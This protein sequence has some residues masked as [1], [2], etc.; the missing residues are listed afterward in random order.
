LTN[1]S[2]Y[3]SM[4][5]ADLGLPSKFQSFRMAQK[6]A[7]EWLME[8]CPSPTSAACL[9]TGVGKTA[10]AIAL[11]RL[12]GVKT[13]YLVATKQLQEQV[14]DEFQSMGMVDIRGR[15]NYDCPN[16]GNCEIGSDRECS[17]FN[18][19]GCASSN[20]DERAE[21]AD[22]IVS[23]YACWLHRR[24][25]NR[26]AFEWE[27]RPIELVILDEAHAIES[28]L[29][30]YASFRFTASEI[31]DDIRCHLDESG[32]MDNPLSP[33]AGHPARDWYLWADKTIKVCRRKKERVERAHPDDY[34]KVDAWE[35]A[36]E[37]ESKA[38]QVS[39]MGTNWVWQFDGYGNADFQ[40]IY[41]KGYID[42]LFSGVARRLMM[43]ASLTTFAIN[44]LIDHGNDSIEDNPYDYRA[45]SQVFPPQNSPVYHIP[46]RKLS[47]KSTD[48]D[49]AAVIQAMDR[50]IES[51]PRRKHIIHTVSYARARQVIGQSRFRE[52][53]LWNDTASGLG[54]ALK[55]FRRAPDG[56]ILVTPSAEESFNF[57]GR[58][59]EV[60][61]FIKFPFPNETSRVIKERCTRI[62]G[63]RLHTAAQRFYQMCGR[64]RRFSSDRCENFC[65]DNSVKQLTG[66]EGRSYLPPGFRIFTV[67]SIPPT[68]PRAPEHAD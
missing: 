44:Q 45:W 32:V 2:T 29:T 11:S 60:Q 12:L 17:L 59:C 58:E 25:A 63:Y 33:S 50:V 6:E 31:E 34:R 67:T 42:G 68:P 57:P 61:H 3:T 53:F 10:L 51:R 35:A 38:L 28:Q 40:P 47:W 20:A 43:S 27:L 26:H 23:N 15:A 46:T 62:P 52:E 64:A 4:T 49:Y 14:S 30:S 1:S 13:M 22:L 37:L 16:Y 39:R 19:S 7:L 66:M 8:E 48:D 54:D 41:L 24:R 55:R 36:N 9:P 5:P 21:N 56:A 65:Y 18:T